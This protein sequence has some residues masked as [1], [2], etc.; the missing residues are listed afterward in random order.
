M[1]PTFLIVNGPQ[2]TKALNSQDLRV[3]IL[4]NGQATM[5][6]SVS[7]LTFNCSQYMADR[8]KKEIRDR[9]NLVDVSSS[10]LRVQN[11]KKNHAVLCLKT[12]DDTTVLVWPKALQ[13]LSAEGNKLVVKASVP[14]GVE[15]EFSIVCQAVLDDQVVLVE[16]GAMLVG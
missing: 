8:I 11:L 3:A 1:K 13:S 7:H 12:A 15:S 9:Y 14:R 6:T 5:A 2:G 10:G 16:L 4:R